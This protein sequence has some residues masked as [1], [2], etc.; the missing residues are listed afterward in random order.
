MSEDAKAVPFAD[1]VA[2][3]RDELRQAQQDADPNL[4]IE[5][6]SVTVE[7]TVLT[8]QEGEGKAGIR[9]WVV[10]AGVSGKLASESTQKVSMELFPLSPTGERARI[11]DIEREYGSRS[12]EQRRDVERG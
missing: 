12:S 7:F 11:R 10:E 6:G 9:F 2:A 4:P 8:R 3:L 5:V 1:F